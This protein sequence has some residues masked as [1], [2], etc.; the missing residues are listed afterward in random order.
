MPWAK[1]PKRPKTSSGQLR[2]SKFEVAVEEQQL[3]TVEGL[4][5][6]YERVPL[7]WMPEVKRRQKT[8]DWWITTPTGQEFVLEGKGYW[9][10]PDRLSETQAVLQNPEYDIRYLFQRDQAIRKGSKTKY[11]DWCRKHGIAA[12]VGVIPK[13]WLV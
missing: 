1:R 10:P 11:T 12:A 9:P 5:F 2:R 4:T 6:D 13:E 3:L 8:F 7:F